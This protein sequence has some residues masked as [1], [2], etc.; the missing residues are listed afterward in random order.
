MQKET[1]S[2]GEEKLNSDYMNKFALWLTTT[3]V[4]SDLCSVFLV[5][6]SLNNNP[7]RSGERLT[8]DPVQLLVDL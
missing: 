4:N 8:V 6:Y 2:S 1:R 7:D 3:E 5:P